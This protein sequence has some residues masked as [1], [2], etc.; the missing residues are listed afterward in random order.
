MGTSKDSGGFYSPVSWVGLPSWGQER[1]H[2]FGGVSRQPSGFPAVLPSDHSPSLAVP[3]LAHRLSLITW[4]DC[5][6]GELP[7]MPQKRQQLAL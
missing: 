7:A 6:L 5:L 1:G 2:E 4:F 3:L